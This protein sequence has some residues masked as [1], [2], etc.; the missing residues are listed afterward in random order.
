MDTPTTQN[1]PFASQKHRR[2]AP[3]IVALAVVATL[4]SGYVLARQGRLL[5]PGL[6]PGGTII[7]ASIRGD[8]PLSSGSYTLNVDIAQK[9]A[10]PFPL[11][12]IVVASAHGL[13]G[14]AAP[15]AVSLPTTIASLTGVITVQG[16]FGKDPAGRLINAQR[17]Q[18]S[19]LSGELPITFDF[20]TRFLDQTVYLN[21]Q[22]LLELPGLEEVVTTNQ[23]YSLPSSAI[24]QTI[25]WSDGMVTNIDSDEV[26]SMVELELSNGDPFMLHRQAGKK[27]IGEVAARRYRVVIQSERLVDFFERLQRRA[28]T[29]SD[30][31]ARDE[32]ISFL[33]TVLSATGRARLHEIADSAGLELWVHPATG[34]LLGGELVLPIQDANAADGEVRELTVSL[35]IENR[36]RP[37]TVTAPDNS[38]SFVDVL[39][40]FI[41]RS[42]QQEQPGE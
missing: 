7:L 2:R 24:A 36:N 30:P 31:S 10:R 19:L 35:T 9:I 13:A 39:S 15:H 11:R 33:R 32:V 41:P 26:W 29:L 17:L 38:T 27:M 23:W 21:A 8:S 1:H 12:G 4:G 20:D 22:K 6:T 25:P 37:V 3:L 34:E 5:I 16:Q 18:G 28:L 40:L 14:E 42:L